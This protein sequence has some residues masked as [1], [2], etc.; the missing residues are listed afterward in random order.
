MEVT[1]TVTLMSPSLASDAPAVAGDA[2][3]L[4]VALC[5]ELSRA[6]GINTVQGQAEYFGVSRGYMFRL[7]KHEQ[8][9][10]LPLG[11]RMAH[12]L[13]VSPYRLF[14]WDEVSA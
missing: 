9:P 5:D 4:D 3:K 2:C 10:S 11:L 8:T 14:G 6:C 7:R 1:L 12:L 13:H